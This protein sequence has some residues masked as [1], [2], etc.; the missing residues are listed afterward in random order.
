MASCPSCSANRSGTDVLPPHRST[1]R[2][3]LGRS[4][5]DRRGR[6][7]CSDPAS[8][9]ALSTAVRHHR[10]APL[11]WFSPR[12]DGHR[13]DRCGAGSVE[14]RIAPGPARRRR[15]SR[16]WR[17]GRG[18]ALHPTLA[19]RL[20]R[21]TG[22]R[23]GAALALL[24]ELPADFW[25]DYDPAF[26]RPGAL[27]ADVA[28]R[29]AR[30]TAPSARAGR[31]G[32]G[33]GSRA[34]LARRVRWP[35]LPTRSPAIDVLIAAGLVDVSERLGLALSHP[36]TP[37]VAAAV[38]GFAGRARARRAAPRSRR[39]V[40]DPVARLAHLVAATP[41]PD[42]GLADELDALAGERARTGEWAAVAELLARAV[43]ADVGVELRE[44]RLVAGLRRP[45][46]LGRHARRR[47]RRGRGREP[48]RDAA[49]QRGPGLPRDRAG[50]PGRGG[51]PAR[52]GLGPGQRRARSRR[53][54]PD[55]PSVGAAQPGPLPRR[56]TSSTGPIVPSSSR[57][58][59]PPPPSRRLRSAASAWP[60]PA[61]ARGARRLRPVRRGGRTR[62]PGPARRDGSGLAGVR[63]RRGRRGPRDAGVGDLDRLPRRLDPD[64]SV[65]PCLACPGAVRQR[66]VGRRPADGRAGQP[67][68]RA[69]RH[70]ADRAAAGLDA[71]PG[72][73]PAR[74]LGAADGPSATPRRARATTS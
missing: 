38:L 6:A 53:R 4:R 50:A 40:D 52:S 36:P 10:S 5:S 64:L 17:A 26:P 35:A 32:G 55:L 65:G 56:R 1:D 63:S 37:M 16:R 62:R 43:P 57:P 14:D 54:R 31:G 25:A 9:Q 23:P 18:L 30:L 68:G 24:T 73:R 47:G 19:D 21:F 72:A 20:C 48:A 27:F 51:E 22:G 13:D 59:A 74:R 8:L 49:A 29:L 41:L 71:G 42:A 12:P 66:R 2:R 3:R 45:G 67:A 60:A 7:G 34:G 15:A 58:P 46:R 69:H 61:V 44:D 33:P 11:S 70:A 39:L 28:A